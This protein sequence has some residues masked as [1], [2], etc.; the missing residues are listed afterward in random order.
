MP[1]S[2]HFGH[3]DG[4][5]VGATFS[6]RAELRI[7]GLHRPPMAGISGSASGGADSIVMSGG[8]E[9]DTDFG[10]VVVYTGHGGNDPTT[11]KQVADQRLTDR[12]LA[13][14]TSQVE[15]LPVRL[16]RG[17][18][19]R[20]SRF[21]PLHGYR[22]DGLYYVDDHWSE[23]GIAG[24][25]VWR[26]RLIR[27]ESTPIP[28]VHPDEN[29]GPLND[30]N[31]PVRRRPANVQRLVRNTSVVRRV[32]SLHGNRCQ[33]C[34]VRLD[35]AAGPY[36][37]GAHIRPLGAPHNGPDVENNVLCLCPNHHVLF[38]YGG[39]VV[40]SNL[41]VMERV[42]GR[43]LGPLRMISGHKLAGVHLAHHRGRFGRVE[44]PCSDLE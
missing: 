34:G 21:R 13:L 35:T 24:F 29:D 41:R 40:G 23:T 39:I 33:V 6:S 28:P 18:G 26:F 17:A 14:V 1:Q 12:N 31:D 25:L 44:V 43:D 42:T 11:K 22:Y 7:A 2:R 10:D 15:G 36:S 37:E 32:K 27:D 16:I 9:D 19:L 8:Y 5:P 38:D 3:I 30:T 4:V 20:D